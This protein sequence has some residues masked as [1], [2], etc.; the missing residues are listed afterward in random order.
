MLKLNVMFFLLA[1]SFQSNAEESAGGMRYSKGEKVDYA[2]PY[3]TKQRYQTNDGYNYYR[4][5]QIVRFG[6]RWY[7]YRDY[8]VSEGSEVVGAGSLK[9][10]GQAERAYLHHGNPEELR[11][12]QERE[13][14]IEKRHQEYVDTTE[15]SYANQAA[16]HAENVRLKDKTDPES[17][18]TRRF[19]NSLI[20]T[21]SIL[22]RLE[23]KYHAEDLN[24]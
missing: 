3:L 8:E 18:R 9:T 2:A 23:A 17:N 24:P 15:R 11:K 10:A 14:A 16:R 20:Q 19:N 7:I 1:V 5:G 12:I 13:A 22:S 21:Q 6:N 4:G